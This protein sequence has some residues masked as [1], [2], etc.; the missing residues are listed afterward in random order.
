[1]KRLNRLFALGRL[2]ISFPSAVPAVFTWRPFSITS[3]RMA[4]VLK[5]QGIWPKSVLDAG[6]NVGQFARAMAETFPSASMVSFEPLPE[7]AERFRKNLADCR[8]VRL[9]ETAVGSFDGNVTFYPQ[10]YDLASSALQSNS[11]AG[12][13][14]TPIEVPLSRL[15]SVLRD[16]ELPG[17]VLLKLDLQGYELEALRGAVQTLARTDYVLLEIALQPAY[18]GEPDFDMLNDFLRSQ[19]FVFRSPIDLL[20]GEKGEVLQ[21]DALYVRNPTPAP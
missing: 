11:V 10:E 9:V 12:Q 8:R 7:V 4:Q 18:S 13:Q 2:G 3:F 15:D 6:A 19:G 17:P 21:M 16:V 14:P 20:R 5:G 1:M